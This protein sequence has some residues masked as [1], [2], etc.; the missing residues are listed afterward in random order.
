[1]LRCDAMRCDTIPSTSLQWCNSYFLCIFCLLWLLLQSYR[2]NCW[3]KPSDLTCQRYRPLEMQLI[4]NPWTD[5]QELE[6]YSYLLDIQQQTKLNFERV[7]CRKIQDADGRHSESI[8]F[9]VGHIFFQ[10]RPG[11][12]QYISV[13]NIALFELMYKN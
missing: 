12:I 9:S 7:Q 3:T 11:I 1:M 10:N 8:S 6:T 4:R 5:Y 2:N 13:Q